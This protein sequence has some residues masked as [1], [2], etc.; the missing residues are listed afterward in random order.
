MPKALPCACLAPRETSDV[1]AAKHEQ[2]KAF[3]TPYYIAP[4][5]I[6]GEMDIDGRADIYSL[7]GT[8]YHMVTGRV[9]FDASAPAEVMKK[10]LKEA[11]VPPDH[12][13]TALSAG[14]SEVIEVMMAK[15]KKDRYK[16][17]EEGIVDLQAVRDG[18]SPLIARQRFNLEALGELEDGAAVDMPN[19]KTL[20]TTEEALTKYKMIVIIL[21]ALS[22][23]L[24]LAV[25]FMALSR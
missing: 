14:I 5:Q 12:I 20:R 23:V 8:L 2:G 18:K 1:R 19:E 21:A 6:R 3:G 17:M 7:G 13:N 4:E 10:H 9:P 24:L 11:L 22:A 25:L 15:D 16:N